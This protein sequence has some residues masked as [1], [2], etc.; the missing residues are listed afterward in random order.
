MNGWSCIILL[1]E[2]YQRVLFPSLVPSVVE[3]VADTDHE[4]VR[5]LEVVELVADLDEAVMPDIRLQGEGVVPAVGV[6]STADEIS[7]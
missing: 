4:I 1:F 7:S 6:L 5:I 2:K 3:T